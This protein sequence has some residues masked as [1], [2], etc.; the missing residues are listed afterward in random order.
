MNPSLNAAP[1][2]RLLSL[3]ESN[4]QG[5]NLQR[6]KTMWKALKRWLWD[7]RGVLITTPTLAG[8]VLLIRFVGL[9]QAWEWAAFDQT[10]RLR[11]QEP[12]DERVVIVGINETDVQVLKK[13]IIPDAVYAELI[14]KLRARNPRAI[15]LDIY[16]DVPV[17]PGHQALVEVFNSTPNLVGIR[18]VVGEQGQGAIAPPPALAAKGQVGSNDLISDADT[19]VRRGLVSVDDSDGNTVY[20]FGLY[21][22]L[23]YLDA[24]G[25]KPEVIGEAKPGETPPWKL[26]KTL[27]QPLDPNY[28]G[29]VRTEEGGYQVMLNYRGPAR[30]F[31]IVSLMDVLQDKVPQD[32]GRDRVIL[33]GYLGESFQDFVYTPYSSGLLSLPERMAGVEVHANLT[34]QFISAAV[35]GR[36]LIQ[37]WT[38]PAEW[39]WIVLWSGV[40]ATLAWQLRYGRGKFTFQQILTPFLALLIL[41][42]SAYIAL[43]WG[44]WIPVVPPAIALVGSAIAITGYIAR[45]A[46]DIRKTF[47][48][49]LSDEVVATLLENPEG[50]KLG[51]ERRKMTLLTSDLRGFT[52]LSERLSPEEVVTILNIYLEEMTEVITRYYGTINNFIGDGIFVLFGAPVERQDDA[53]RAIAC[54]IAMQLALKSVNEKLQQLNFPNLAMGIGIHT[55][56]SVI[57]NIGST[58]RSQYSAIGSQVNLT[59]RIESYTLEG[60]ILISESTL[61]EVEPIVEIVGQQEVQ[62][63]GVIQP[64]TIYEISAIRGTYALELPQQTETWR[65]LSEPILIQYATLEGKHISENVYQ[66]HLI[67]LSEQGAVVK[68][69]AEAIAPLPKKLTNL[70]LNLVNTPG[71]LSE[72]IYAKVHSQDAESGC[73]QIRF[74]NIPPALR[75]QL[76]AVYQNQG[77]PV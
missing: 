35:N 3:Q 66:G 61:K 36:P 16:R 77:F 73:F 21:L 15:G 32:W 60:Q 23:L 71:D 58:K 9:L 63:K 74:T 72:D 51:G 55:G 6:A 33:I 1:Q 19:K 43:V 2:V 49:Y 45:S 53:E 41:L 30:H 40:G 54:A 76:E 29:Y 24:E 5:S 62:P 59:F 57:G 70:K 69:Q 48:R 27:F 7:W 26:G 8:L 47:G 11:P 37:T 31:Q 10:L 25:I 52:S 38:E 13:A 44:W 64:I 4:F 68:V 14:Q 22:A 20:G 34:S 28:G 17:E 42:A 18:K 39:L 56:E 12:T 65:S 46:G 50:L 75:P 67:Q